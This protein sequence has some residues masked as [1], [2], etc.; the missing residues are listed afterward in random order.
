MWPHHARIISYIVLPYRRLEWSRWKE[1][2]GLFLKWPRK[3]SHGIPAAIHLSFSIPFPTRG[4]R[5]FSLSLFSFF[6]FLQHLPCRYIEHYNP[7]Y[8]RIL[9]DNEDHDERPFSSPRRF[10]ITIHV[11]WLIEPRDWLYT[12]PSIF[13]RSRDG[14]VVTHV[15]HG[16][17]IASRKLFFALERL[18]H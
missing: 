4:V 13:E 9:F 2:L 1:F 17:D 7:Y 18:L 6:F 12:F 11:G 10:L 14:M 16:V 8:A 15:T 5:F 3:Y